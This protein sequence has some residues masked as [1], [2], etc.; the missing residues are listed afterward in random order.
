MSGVMAKV[1]SL[2]AAMK[3]LFRSYSQRAAKGQSAALDKEKAPRD[4]IRSAFHHATNLGLIVV[5]ITA[6]AVIAV[7]IA[8]AI[9]VTA[10]TIGERILDTLL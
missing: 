3:W 5:A 6:P 7:A 9:A 1:G 10:I 2:F 4:T 8:V